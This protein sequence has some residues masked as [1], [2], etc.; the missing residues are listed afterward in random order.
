MSIN[1]FSFDSENISF[2]S[3]NISFDSENI[4]FGKPIHKNGYVSVSIN[5]NY[6]GN[7]V[8]PLI[9]ET[10]FIE[11]G[12]YKKLSKCQRKNRNRKNTKS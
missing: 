11:I 12:K 6:P 9:I 1:I 5:Y 3:E 7:V 10:P 8:K 4:S 2:D